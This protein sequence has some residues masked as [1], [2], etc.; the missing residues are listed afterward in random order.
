MKQSIKKA[1]VRNLHYTPIEKFSFHI[2]DYLGTY[3]NTRA[4]RA[5][6]GKMSI[7]FILER[8][9]NEPEQYH[10]RLIHYFVKTYT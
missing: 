3:N 6:K 2:K 9:Y 8:W 5:H 1:T 4:L 10:E 7:G